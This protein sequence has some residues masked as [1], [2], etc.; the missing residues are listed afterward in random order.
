MNEEMRGLMCDNGTID[1]TDDDETASEES[2]PNTTTPS[3]RTSH[4]SPR[5]ALTDSILPSSSGVTCRVCT[6]LHPPPVPVCCESCNNVLEPQT[7]PPGQ[8]WDCTASNCPGREVGYVNYTDVGRCGIC[9]A[10][11]D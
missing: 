4:L 7:L 10:K 9:S 5:S 3:P 2:P 11:K 6:T 1:L 8:T